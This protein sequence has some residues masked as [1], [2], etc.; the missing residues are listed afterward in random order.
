MLFSHLFTN[1]ENDSGG[2]GSGIEKVKVELAGEVNCTGRF[3]QIPGIQC[4]EK[5]V[6]YRTVIQVK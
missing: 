3:N 5:W 1:S 4:T 2:E 6:P